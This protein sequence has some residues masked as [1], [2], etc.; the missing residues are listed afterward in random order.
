MKLK[1]LESALSEAEQFG[2]GLPPKLSL[3]QYS[4]P[5]HLAARLIHAAHAAGDIEGSPASVPLS[6]QQAS[7]A[8]S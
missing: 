7:H 3:E 4:T 5:P 6:E 1:A 8:A 2:E